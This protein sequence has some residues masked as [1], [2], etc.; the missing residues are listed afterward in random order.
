MRLPHFLLHPQK[1]LLHCHQLFLPLSSHRCW[2]ACILAV[3]LCLGAGVTL[4]GHARAQTAAIT[5]PIVHVAL[6]YQSGQL[7]CDFVAADEATLA[8]AIL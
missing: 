5:F 6:S 8:Q 7:A 3:L 4:P 1:L 2:P